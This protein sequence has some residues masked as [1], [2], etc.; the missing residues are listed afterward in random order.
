MKNVFYFLSTNNDIL[1]FM[2][3]MKCDRGVMLPSV[4]GCDVAKCDRGV[5]LPNVTGV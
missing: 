3:K 1:Q 2:N 4:T 5:M